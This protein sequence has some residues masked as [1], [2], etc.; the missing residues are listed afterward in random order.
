MVYAIFSIFAI[1]KLEPSKQIKWALLL[2]SLILF[3]PISKTL[4]IFPDKEIISTI[5]D[6]NHERAES[7][8][9]RFIN[10]KVLLDRALEKPYFGWSGWGRN[11]IYDMY[12]KDITITD[13]K[14]IIEFGLYGIFGFVFYYLILLMPL[15]Y[16]RKNINYIQE[17]KDK[18]YFAALAC[19]LGVCIIDSVPN[20]GMGPIHLLM[21]GALL[22]QSELLAKQKKLIGH[23]NAKSF[24]A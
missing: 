9:T 18:V 13:G 3:Y 12:G 22:G 7:L 5:K 23:S 6:F 17:P 20:T 21:A 24:N 1:Y 14:W 19:I 11:R 15:V 10:E 4:E 8:E 2:A 16:A